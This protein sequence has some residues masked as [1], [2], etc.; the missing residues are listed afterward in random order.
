MLASCDFLKFYIN[1]HRYFG[2]N[3]GILNS[4]YAPLKKF[5]LSLLKPLTMSADKKIKK[6]KLPEPV[7]EDNRHR[8]QEEF[9]DKSRAIRD[10]K[11]KKV[12]YIVK[13]LPIY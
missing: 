8:S 2:I 13:D 7:K 9:D 11:A 5:D 4:P 1:W 3:R 10:R 6:E 12:N